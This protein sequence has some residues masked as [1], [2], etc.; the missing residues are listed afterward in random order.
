MP[1]DKKTILV[2]DD[3]PEIRKL[4]GAMVGQFGYQ[5]ITADSGEHALTLYKNHN[6]VELLI[7]DVIAPGMSGPMLADKLTALQPDLKVLYISGYDNTQVV[8]KYVVEKGH[9]LLAKPFTV[10]ELQAKVG[11]LLGRAVHQAGS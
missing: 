3:E 8:Q 4:V 5:V 11:E 10:A 7:T 2:V 9:A 6:P 1:E